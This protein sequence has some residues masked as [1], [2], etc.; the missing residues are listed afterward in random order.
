MLWPKLLATSVSWL[1]VLPQSHLALRVKSAVRTQNGRLIALV[2]RWI[3][4][5]L[6][7]TTAFFRRLI[8][9]RLFL[10]HL[11]L[12]MMYFVRVFR[13]FLSLLPKTVSLTSTLPML[14]RLRAMLARPLWVLVAQAAMTVPLRLHSRQ[15]SHR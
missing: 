14:R 11:R 12:P 6:F 5:L 3:H 4:L 9:A 1:L 2:V 15:L 10:R 8:V 13:V 7:Q